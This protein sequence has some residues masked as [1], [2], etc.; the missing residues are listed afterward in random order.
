MCS[1]EIILK[2]DLT[3][4]QMS[5]DMRDESILYVKWVLWFYEDGR[6]GYYFPRIVKRCWNS[7][8]LWEVLL[9]SAVNAHW[10]FINLLEFCR[11]NSFILAWNSFS[12]CPSF[13]VFFRLNIVFFLPLSRNEFWM[14][15]NRE[16]ILWACAIR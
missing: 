15:T 13:V 8:Q 16:Y 7:S 2:I 4:S 12:A 10:I 14:E 11:I 1:F 5:S 9:N 3:V 6:I